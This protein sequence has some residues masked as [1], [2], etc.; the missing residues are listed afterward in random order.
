[1]ETFLKITTDFLLPAKF[2]VLTFFWKDRCRM[3]SRFSIISANG[4]G[5][6]FR[7]VRSRYYFVFSVINE[8]ENWP[9]VFFKRRKIFFRAV[10]AL[11][12][13]SYSCW[14]PALFPQ[15]LFSPLL[16]GLLLLAI[17]C[18]WLYALVFVLSLWSAPIW[19]GFTS[20]MMTWPIRYWTDVTLSSG[21]VQVWYDGTAKLEGNVDPSRHRTKPQYSTP[22]H[23]FPHDPLFA[24]IVH[25]TPN[26]NSWKSATHA[27][28]ESWS[29]FSLSP[30]WVRVLFVGAEKSY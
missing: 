20:V 1:M 10:L 6:S 4:N 12:L 16:N 27:G 23:H 8:G 30:T 17:A 28:R 14:W 11:L 7:S 5:G 29:S 13:L 26:A 9:K 19:S 22:L 21:L 2:W 3:R 25:S 15:L 24:P 18:K